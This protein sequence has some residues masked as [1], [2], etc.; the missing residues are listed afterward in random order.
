MELI[1]RTSRR[2]E[3][4]HPSGDKSV[5]TKADVWRRS[6]NAY[7]NSKEQCQQSSLQ[8][9]RRS[10]AAY[11]TSKDRCQKS[12]MQTWRRSASA[13]YNS[14]DRCHQTTV[15]TWHRSAD[16]WARSKN[17]CLKSTANLLNRSAD[18]IYRP[19]SRSD[20]LE[21]QPEKED[22]EAPRQL[23]A[24]KGWPKSKPEKSQSVIKSTQI[25]MPRERS[26]SS[27]S[28]LALNRPLKL[29]E[30]DPTSSAS[31]ALS[32]ELSTS[33]K[34]P[35]EQIRSLLNLLDNVSTQAMQAKK[36]RDS[37][38]PCLGE[39]EHN[40]VNSTIIDA[41]DSAQDLRGLLEIYSLD[42]SKRKG[43]GKVASANRK[44][45][46]LRDC[47]FAKE[48]QGRLIRH[49]SRLERVIAHL[50]MLEVPSNIDSNSTTDSPISEL[51]EDCV[52]ELSADLGDS[53]T[54]LAKLP[55]SP[56][57]VPRKPVSVIAELPG[58]PIVAKVKPMPPIPK[59][60][61][62]NTPDGSSYDYIGSPDTTHSNEINEMSKFLSWKETRNSIRLQQSESFSNIITKM[63][64]SRV[65]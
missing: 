44:R 22:N 25:S 24:P 8:T 19:I 29:S 15:E 26:E 56:A 49:R 33:K 62:T 16:A 42:L 7:R 63:E 59:I 11:H 30:A 37:K 1:D 64:R 58:N 2:R 5:Q 41:E 9:W 47:Q 39:I 38:S 40:W 55:F 51:E 48:R 12:T 35:D 27:V 53:P 31:Q 13:Y 65:K 43:K 34:R 46:K 6:T 50:E 54:A 3:A 14:K 17:I 57:P 28:S 32:V 18:K 60:I 21:F 36:I 52:P 20:L 4:E 45:W 61:V 10:T 23:E